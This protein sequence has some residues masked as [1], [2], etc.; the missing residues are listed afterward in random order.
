LGGVS[1][2]KIATNRVVGS[3]PIGYYLKERRNIL[4]ILDDLIKSID[5]YY[6]FDIEGNF[7]YGTLAVASHDIPQ[8]LTGNSASRYGD[9]VYE[10]TT[11]PYTSAT[12]IKKYVLASDQ[13][14]T[15]TTKPTL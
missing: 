14:A 13:I 6:G 1:L 12:D 5:G 10:A 3:V 11:S 2:D 9:V 8:K 7:F 15:N 4:D